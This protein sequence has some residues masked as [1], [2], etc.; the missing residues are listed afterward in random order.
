[1]SIIRGRDDSPARR[2]GADHLQ[3]ADDDRVRT[4]VVKDLISCDNKVSIE[5]TILTRTFRITRWATHAKEESHGNKQQYNRL[6]SE[7]R[8]SLGM[9]L[10][11]I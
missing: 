11:T 9:R 6:Q 3:C 5:A 1:L 10:K 4:H 2:N 7:E 8:K